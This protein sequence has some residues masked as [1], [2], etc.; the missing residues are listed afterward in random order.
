LKGGNVE[1]L[2]RNGLRFQTQVL[3]DS[4]N[5]QFSN[6]LQKQKSGSSMIRTAAFYVE[7]VAQSQGRPFNPSTF[8]PFN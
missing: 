8:Q 2:K 6:H 3:G 1:E 7:C 5:F 4:V